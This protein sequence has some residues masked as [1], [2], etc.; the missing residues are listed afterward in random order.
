VKAARRALRTHRRAVP[1]LAWLA[2]AGLVSP[3]TAS[4]A[5]AESVVARAG[6]TAP[7]PTSASLPAALVSFEA[8]EG[9][10]LFAEAEKA[11]FWPLV[12]TFESERLDTYCAVASG[13]M[14]LNALGVPSPPQPLVFPYH[15][16]D[17]DN[18][19][20]EAVLRVAAA[21]AVAAAGMTLDQLA[22]SLRA[23]GV[24]VAVH[25]AADTPVDRFRSLAREAVAKGDRFVVVNLWRAA[26]GQ[27][28]PGHF[29]PVAAY[30]QK[31]DRFL[32]MDVARYKYAPWWV[33]APAL[34]RAMD[35][36]DPTAG[37][38]RGFLVVSRR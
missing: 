25:H 15:E 18:F 2:V 5:R 38:T 37:E 23:W 1:F 27:V 32:V 19:F 9:A 31:S 4:V 33:E 30:H 11:L 21:P 20:S 6:E 28:G 34:W 10:G 26:I 7:A 29:S 17:Q 13:V 22:D 36:E 12:R 14:V 24:D 16:F 3:G 8:P 35:T